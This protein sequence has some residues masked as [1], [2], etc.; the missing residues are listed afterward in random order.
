MSIQHVS[1]IIGSRH[2]HL[3]HLVTTAVM[4]VMPCFLIL[5]P[6]CIKLFLWVAIMTRQASDAVGVNP[7][8]PM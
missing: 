6:V 4:V 7:K 1:Y 3:R 2:V 8:V 5:A